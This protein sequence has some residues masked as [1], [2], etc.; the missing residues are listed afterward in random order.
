MDRVEGHVDILSHEDGAFSV[1]RLEMDMGMQVSLCV[2]ARDIGPLY[3]C[4]VYVFIHVCTH[5]C[6]CVRTCTYVHF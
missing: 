6:T 4:A 3:A 5:I 2:C 1:K